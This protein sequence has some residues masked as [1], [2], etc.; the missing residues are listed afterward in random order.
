MSNLQQRIQNLM[1]KS[2]EFKENLEILRMTNPGRIAIDVCEMYHDK[3]GFPEI[4]DY[5]CSGENAHVLKMQGF[6]NIFNELAKKNLLEEALPVVKKSPDKMRRVLKKY[7][8]MDCIYDILEALEAQEDIEVSC[9]LLNTKIM[10]EIMKNDP[11]KYDIELCTW[12]IESHKRNDLKSLKA[13]ID[14]GLSEQADNATIYLGNTKF[15][16]FAE[17]L[18]NNPKIMDHVNN[19][20]IEEAY[21]KF[22]LQYKQPRLLEAYK[23]QINAS[24]SNKY[25][26]IKAINNFFKDNAKI[27]SKYFKLKG[28]DIVISEIVNGLNNNNYDWTMDNM[29]KL[30][31]NKV[32]QKYQKKKAEKVAKILGHSILEYGE[33]SD[34]LTKHYSKRNIRL[35][36]DVL[37]NHSEGSLTSLGQLSEVLDMYIQNREII[38][39]VDKLPAFTLECMLQEKVKEILDVKPSFLQYLKKGNLWY[40]KRLDKSILEN[41]TQKEFDVVRSTYTFIEGIHREREIGAKEVIGDYFFE[42]LTRAYNQGNDVDSKL[43]YLHQFCKEVKQRMM[44]NASDLMV[45]KSA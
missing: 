35:A 8:K 27:F 7:H 23:N 45:I 36:I 12:F 1:D 41:C 37:Y 22:S 42:E 28:G 18:I 20:E 39:A 21:L 31:S 26:W 33:V 19:G 2:E 4:V 30:A 32:L 17:A 43:G 3:D 9:D 6:T 15:S 34:F 29:D 16:L 10:Q 14:N 11:S 13:V 5:L 24:M 38:Q 44:D 40:I 25:I